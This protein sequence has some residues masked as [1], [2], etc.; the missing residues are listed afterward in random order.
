M[1]K[2]KY[3]AEMDLLEKEHLDAVRSLK[4]KFAFANNPYQMGDIIKDHQ[5]IIRIEK[6]QATTANLQ[7]Y[8]ECV[9]SGPQLK[10]DLTPRKDGNRE[11]IWQSNVK[12]KITE[13]K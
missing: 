10:K 7:K 6:I 1:D 2:E 9:Y 13:V 4:V 5:S 3:D 8:P 12:E 11:Q